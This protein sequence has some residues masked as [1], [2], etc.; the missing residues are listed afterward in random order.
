MNK[1]VVYLTDVHCRQSSWG[2]DDLVQFRRSAAILR[3]LGLSLDTDHGTTDE[4][5]PWFV[6]CHADSG[7]VIAHCARIGEAY[8]V[9]APWLKM[10]LQGPAL[11]DLLECLHDGFVYWTG[12]VTAPSLALLAVHRRRPASPRPRARSG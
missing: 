6:F 9:C 2:T 4:G 12:R 3:R 5:E 8:V 10:S 11:V 7:D 1:R